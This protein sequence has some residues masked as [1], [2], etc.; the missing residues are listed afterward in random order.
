MIKIYFIRHGEAD[1]SL[2][3]TKFYIGYGENFNSL[4]EHGIK[5]IKETAK[6]NRLKTCNIIL[7]SPYTR[8]LFS[9]AILS[10][11]LNIDLVV[12]PDLHE[13][14]NDYEYKNIVSKD[15]TELEEYNKYNGE[16]PDDG[17]SRTWECNEMLRKRIFSTLEKYKDYEKIIVVCHGILIHSL[18]TDKWMDNAEVFEYEMDI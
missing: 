8:A 16:Y 10:K 17:I 12:E 11:E 14:V 15:G 6:D 3:G 4:T 9:A 5:Q 7:S 1:Y 13:W 18:C 2:F